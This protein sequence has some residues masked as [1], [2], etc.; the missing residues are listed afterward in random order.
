MGGDEIRCYGCCHNRD[1][2][3]PR[4]ILYVSL[5][6]K[7]SSLQA[8]RGTQR[9]GPALAPQVIRYLSSVFPRSSRR[10]TPCPVIAPSWIDGPS[11]PRERPPRIHR[12]PPRNFAGSTLFHF[13]ES[14]PRDLS[15][16]LRDSAPGDHWFK[17]YQLSH[18]QCHQDQNSH[19]SQD[20]KRILSD[21]S[22]D[23]TQRISRKKSEPACRAA[24]SGPAA[25]P[26]RSPSPI[27]MDR[28]TALP[29]GS[30]EIRL[31]S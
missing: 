23:L 2:D 24:R 25:A 17:L 16:H 5:P 4:R 7:T 3:I 11:L 1:Q 13:W 10:E 29:F 28:E 9:Q 22:K 15:L 20:P 6:G 12:K 18:H 26:T 19:P 8:A 14:L 30:Y 27:R 31:F 21:K